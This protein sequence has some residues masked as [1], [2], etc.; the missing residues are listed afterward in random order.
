MANIQKLTYPYFTDGTTQLNA[1][2]LNPIIAK[3]NEV[4]DQVNSGVS[5][6]PTQ[7]V[8][9]P[10]ISISGTTAT[11]SCSTSGATIYYTLNGNTPTTSST[12]YS[13]PITLSEAC[14]IKA[15]AVK[16]G[17][18]NSA[19][20][21]QSY[22]A[23]VTVTTP[24]IAIN[25]SSV[26]ITA[27]SGATLRYTTDGSTPS[28]S[29]GTA[30]NSNTVTFTPSGNCTIKAVAIKSSAVSSVASQSYTVPS[31]GETWQSEDLGS[32]LSTIIN[33]DNVWAISSTN[34]SRMI[35]AVP[36]RQYKI[37]ATMATRGAARDDGAFAFLT[38]NDTTAGDTPSYAGDAEGLSIVVYGAEPTIVTAPSNA[39]YLYIA[40]YRD[41]NKWAICNVSSL[42]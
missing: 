35:P 9:T 13:S 30:V 21:S 17:M 23:S 19:V 4:I 37:E 8:A 36:G 2:N 24:T 6:T 12:Q 16:S 15:I 31:A 1:A 14:T 38:N 42:R 33:R 25:G 3:L 27:E 28:A 7:T 26:T 32:E 34:F 29:S 18:T 11:I 41:G 40:D 22:T 10:T 20:A 5:P 39:A